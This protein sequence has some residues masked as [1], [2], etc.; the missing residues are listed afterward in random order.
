MPL[1]VKHH[2]VILLH[3]KKRFVFS[4]I[5]HNNKFTVVKH[6]VIV[7]LGGRKYFFIF[8]SAVG[9]QLHIYKLGRTTELRKDKFYKYANSQ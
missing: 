9:C 5:N 2:S 8:P 6:K 4:P 1:L 7:M 3:F